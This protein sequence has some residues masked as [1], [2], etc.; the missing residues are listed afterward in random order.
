MPP[1]N[2]RRRHREDPRLSALPEEDRKLI[3]AKREYQ[4]LLEMPLTQVVQLRTAN[5][6]EENDYETVE[7]V[8]KA[9]K[10]RLM[11]IENFGE[12]TMTELYWAIKDLGL[13]T[14]A[15]WGTRYARPKK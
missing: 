13:K 6:L 3:K 8:L 9:T 10:E 5:M 15:D 11:S 4:R 7:A 14:P 12:K 2:R 1:H